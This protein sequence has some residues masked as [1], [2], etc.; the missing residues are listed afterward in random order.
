[1]WHGYSTAALANHFERV[2]GADVF[3]GDVIP[4]TE[5][6]PMI[7][8]TRKS[9][10]RGRTSN[11]MNARWKTSITII[12]GILPSKY[13]PLPIADLIHID[14]SHNYKDWFGVMKAIAHCRV[15]IFHD[16]GNWFVDVP[17]LI[18][19]IA[20]RFNLPHF[21]FPHHEGM[22][23]L[24]CQNMLT[25]QDHVEIR[26]FTKQGFPIEGVVHVGAN[27]GYEIPHY[28]NLGAKKVI[29]IEP[30]KRICGILQQ[31]FGLD[32]RVEIYQVALG[33]SDGNSTLNVSQGDGLG[34][35]LLPEVKVIPPDCEFEPNEI[36]S[37]ETVP[38]R[39]FD[40]MNINTEGCNVLVVDAQGM[41]LQALLGFGDK[42]QD[43]EL[44]NIECSREPVYVGGPAAQEVVD[45]L[46][47]KGFQQETP[48]KGHG[49]IMFR[50]HKKTFPGWNWG[51][52]MLPL[53]EPH[54]YVQ[55]PGPMVL[56][57]VSGRHWKDDS[58]SWEQCVRTWDQN[59]LFRHP[60]YH[61]TGKPI[62][63]AYDEVHRNTTQEIIGY[64][65]DDVSIYENSWDSRVLKE[66]K[67]PVS[68]SSDSLARSVTASRTC[69]TNHARAR[70]SC[71][72]TCA[73]T[74]PM[75]RFTG[76]GSRASAT[77]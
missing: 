61:V 51:D 70:T 3:Y 48:I 20:D 44:L 15:A 55:P 58:G 14:A 9:W 34:S 6:T 62:M 23:I 67:D 42:L 40:S 69:T 22:D 8:T 17:R 60:R 4:G 59:A 76:S 71:A 54:H 37:T 45:F 29:A 5:G 72:S 7:E 41:E 46:A 39:R 16:T 26:H 30:Q 31:K 38:I 75:P 24:V 53:L 64:I 35:S 36:V 77:W 19:E 13:E 56:A 2:I 50:Q 25:A 27:D 57:M 33:G 10:R 52:R 21:H 65:H 28:L 74:W 73:Q 12:A 11:S 63:E 49:D 68:A 47:S 66:F 43:F 18:Y 32:E 1:V